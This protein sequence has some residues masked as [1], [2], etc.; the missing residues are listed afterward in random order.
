MKQLEKYAPHLPYELVI[1]RK[2]VCYTVVG[3]NYNYI[4]VLETEYDEFKMKDVKPYL[5]PLSQL[6]KPITQ[7]DYNGG[8]EFVPIEEIKEW[9]NYQ[10]SSYIK[11]LKIIQRNGII[12]LFGLEDDESYEVA[13]SL[14]AYNFLLKWH[15]NVT[16]FAEGEYISVDN[17]NNNN[18]Y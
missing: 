11:N 12:T 14:Q 6:T 15:F 7:K 16:G 18:P 2:G 9:Y 4:K 13:M 8:K 3:L 17:N 1:E 10:P 5:R